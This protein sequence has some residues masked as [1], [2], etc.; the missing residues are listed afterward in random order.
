MS[1]KERISATI[2]EDLKEWL[3]GNDS[4]NTSGMINEMIRARKEAQA[5]GSGTDMAVLQ[6]Q[7]EETKRKID[8]AERERESIEQKIDSLNEH[9]E[10]LKSQIRSREM[11]QTNKLEEAKE[12]LETATK[13]PDNPA[14]QRWA[15]ELDMSVLELLDELPDDDGDPMP[16]DLS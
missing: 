12:V 6:W 8:D 5:A 15:A 13:S 7:V 14:I 4:I 2:D 10:R 11:E 3:T 9:L 1:G 16:G